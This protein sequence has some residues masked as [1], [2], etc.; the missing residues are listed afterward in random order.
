MEFFDHL[1]TF[2]QFTVGLITILNPIAAAAIMVSLLTPPISNQELTSISK[3]TTLT[4]LIASLLAV[5]L[6][7]LMFKLFD[8]NIHSIKVI[9]GI[10]L[11]LLAISMIKGEIFES[12]SHTPEEHEEAKEKDDISIIPLGIPILFGP[13]TF[14]TIVI[15]KSSAH[16]LIDLILLV[17]AI[18]VSMEVV[19]IVLKNAVLLDRFLGV[20]GVKITTRIMGLIVGAIAS[21]FIVSGVKTLW[22]MY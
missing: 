18:F 19:F 2:L 7:D 8:I 16:S 17:L 20:T 13:G 10:I 3:K 14:T 22:N 11:L 21:Q 12:S 6:G 1:R 5:F 9:G 15:F 4:V